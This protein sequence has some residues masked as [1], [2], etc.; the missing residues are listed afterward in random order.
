MENKTPTPA[1][2]QRAAID[3]WNTTCQL[4]TLLNAWA[5]KR[6]ELFQ[7]I[8]HQTFFWPAMVSRK[9]AIAGE[10]ADLM[11]KIELGKNCLYRNDT[12]WRINEPATQFAIYLHT[13][14][15]T[16]EKQWQLPRLSDLKSKRAWFDRAWRHL[17][18][19]GFDPVQQP[20][21]SKL[22]RRAVTRNY[23]ANEREA[24]K[25]RTWEAY[26]KVIA[27]PRQK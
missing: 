10:A 16:F 8:A 6:P 3:L 1:D 4:V 18:E 9:R 12:Q 7:L 21:I 17:D 14:A 11:E 13:L 5:K 26:D 27:I 19:I 15:K 24:I 2:E 20:V 23:K 22:S 25:D